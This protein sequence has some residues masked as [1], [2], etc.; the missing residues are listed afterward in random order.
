VNERLFIFAPMRTRDIQKE[1]TIREKALEM[2]VK[3]GFDGFSMQK[4]AR[5][6]NVSPATLYIYFVNKEDMLR[7]LYNEVQRTFTRVA[8]DGFDPNVPFAEGLWIQWKNRLCFVED[9]P[10]HFQFME[11]F[12]NSP[13]I[14]HSSIE[15]LSDF[16]D[17][18]KAFLKNAMD[19]G[20]M[21]RMDPELFWSIAYGSLYT[22]IKFH[23][24]EKQLLG[25][26]YKLTEEKLAEAYRMVL[27]AL[28]PESAQRI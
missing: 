26:P 23:L 28:T 2:I 8:L 20:E 5:E 15:P 13:L 24:N 6:A 22:L 7:Q 17:S 11:Q 27:K 4:L 10:H 1:A 19:R 9:Y 3:E 18:M 16:K 12:R 25:R 14:S 21:Q